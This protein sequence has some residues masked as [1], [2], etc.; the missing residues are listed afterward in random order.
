MA[1]VYQGGL[2]GDG[3]RLF[4][5]AD[6]AGEGSAVPE[7]TVSGV[8][9]TNGGPAMSGGSTTKDF[10]DDKGYGTGSMDVDNDPSMKVVNPDDIKS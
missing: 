1:D 7:S 2:P 5:K 4:P 3:T 8:K 9:T 10:L 6:M